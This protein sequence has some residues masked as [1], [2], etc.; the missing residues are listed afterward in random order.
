MYKVIRK[1]TTFVNCV[2]S[3]DTFNLLLKF[4]DKEYGFSL[5]LDIDITVCKVMDLSSIC[6]A[7]KC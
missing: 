4:L 7:C 5:T 2:Y 6:E 1:I 3:L